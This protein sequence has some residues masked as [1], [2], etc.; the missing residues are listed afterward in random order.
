MRRS[1]IFNILSS[2]AIFV[3][4]CSII[5]MAI[6]LLWWFFPVCNESC[7]LVGRWIISGIITSWLI[8]TRKLIIN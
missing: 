8:A 1:R 4:F 6:S 7:M 3:L 5:A 2:M